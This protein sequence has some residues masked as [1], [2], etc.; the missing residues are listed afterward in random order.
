MAPCSCGSASIKADKESGTCSSVSLVLRCAA[1][2]TARPATSIATLRCETAPEQVRRRLTAAPM[3]HWPTPRACALIR[4]SGQET[5]TGQAGHRLLLVHHPWPLKGKIITRERWRQF[6]RLPLYPA[7]H[8]II[9]SELCNSVRHRHLSAS[10]EEVCVGQKPAKP[11]YRAADYTIRIMLRTLR[12]QGAKVL[13]SNS[14]VRRRQT[15][16]SPQGPP[17]PRPVG[18]LRTLRDAKC[19]ARSA[20]V[21][22]RTSRA[23]YQCQCYAGSLPP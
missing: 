17:G 5:V 13:P 19:R 23:R 3:L 14:R 18:E 15:S 10:E 7:F 11:P 22:I 9:P 2:Q 4:K 8:N 20:S 6:D 21:G 12:H 1:P 16:S